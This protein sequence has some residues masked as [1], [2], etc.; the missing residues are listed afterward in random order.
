MAKYEELIY[1]VASKWPGE[2]RH[3]TALRYIR[4]REAGTPDA[5]QAKETP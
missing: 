3:E 4:E 1:A 5:E 2:S